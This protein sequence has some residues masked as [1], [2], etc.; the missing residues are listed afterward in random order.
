MRLLWLVIAFYSPY[1]FATPSYHLQYKYYDVHAWN[2]ER[3]ED[4]IYAS[5]IVIDKG[6]KF[7]GRTDWKVKWGYSM[8]M[9]NE[10]CRIYN[11]KI[12][13]SVVLTMPKLQYAHKTPASI[14]AAFDRHYTELFQHEEQHMR[15][16]FEAAKEVERALWTLDGMADCQQLE[17]TANQLAKLIVDEYVLLD[18]KYDLLTNHGTH[19]AAIEGE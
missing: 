9:V 12:D 19:R 6:K 3:L 16:G 14:I 10:L 1:L 8:L 15:H 7:M 17:L 2:L 5:S 13:Y 4:D 18:K 11:V